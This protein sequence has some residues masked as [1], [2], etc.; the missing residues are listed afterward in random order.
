MQ[1]ASSIRARSN[2]LAAS[3]AKIV[4]L[5]AIITTLAG[6]P[7]SPVVA[8]P[9]ATFYKGRTVTIT[10]SS[11]PGGG[12]DTLSRAI[13]RHIGRHIPGNPQIVAQNMPGA[14]GIVATNFMYNVAP[15]D[16]LMLACVQNNAPLEPLF[17]TKSANY[18]ATKFNW[19]GTPSV[20]V[21][22]MAV[23]HA[24]GVRTIEEARAKPL[25][26]GSSGANSA[27][28]FYAH[29]LNDLMGFKVKVVAGYPGQTQ[30]FLAM[31]RG[32]LDFYGTTFWSALTSTKPDWIANKRL[33]YIVQYGPQKAAE[34]PDVP[35]LR[36]IITKPDDRL[37]LLAAEGPL[38]L[39]RPYLMPPGVPA[40][41]V[42]AIR[43]AFLD[44][45]K[46]KDFLEDAK[47]QKLDIG[48]PR[49]GEEL[50]QE[51][52][53]IYKTPPHIVERLRRIAQQS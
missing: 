10:I 39:G 5:A 37:L 48:S 24:S 11:S 7:P 26:A 25:T 34:L 46:D 14:G 2:R 1:I 47:R 45:L 50:Q 51:L 44:T 52:E 31:E 53:Q 19:V 43:K 4:G 33:N 15:K 40:D 9:I 41:R 3:T 30:A 32:E 6:F 23:W 13:A 17:G 16:G 27:P 20:E 29:L 22:L 18:D 49:R 12:Y 28:S 38:I 21:G 8:D 42:A 35:F 36:D